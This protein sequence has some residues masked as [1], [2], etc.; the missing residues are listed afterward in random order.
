MKFQSYTPVEYCGLDDV[1]LRDNLAF[2]KYKTCKSEVSN[3][4]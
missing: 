3:P 1:N 4:K 2:V